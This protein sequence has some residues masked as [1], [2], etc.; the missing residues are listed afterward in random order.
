MRLHKKSIHK[1]TGQTVSNSSKPINIP[2]ILTW[3]RIAFIP[4]IVGVFYLPDVIL[5][6][7]MKNLLACVMF[8]V[9]AVTDALDGYI[10]RRFNMMTKM[11]AFLDSV[12][13]KLVVCSAIVVLVEFGR[14]PMMV[15]LIIIGRE[16]AVTALREWMAKIGAAATVKVNWF[17]KIKT[18]AQMIAIPMLLFYDPIFGI[19]VK[20]IG[21]ILIWVAAV[22]T[23][24][25]MCV[26][27]A[28]AWP[29]LQGKDS[30]Q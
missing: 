16:I 25:S 26:Y 30:L 7:H 21:T 23:I 8:V 28:A 1:F 3:A 9:A 5:T 22:L 6:P 29:H 14:V 2:M 27:M 10:A 20:L 4:L 19:N 18:I 13:D 17:G 11:G 12:A 15:A 24:Y